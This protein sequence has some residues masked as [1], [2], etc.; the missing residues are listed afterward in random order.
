M[1]KILIIVVI[2]LVLG[3]IDIIPLLLAEAPVFNM[4]SIFAFWIV[5]S[6]IIYKT[7][8]LVNSIVNGMLISLLLMTPLALAVSATNSKDFFP[9]MIMA[10]VL[11]P[12][13]GFLIKKFV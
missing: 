1:K 6:V 11:G 5:A 4:L 8:I 7:K 2:G 12:L 9:M 10:L 3:A 13:C